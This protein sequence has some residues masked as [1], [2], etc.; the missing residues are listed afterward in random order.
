MDASSIPPPSSM[1]HERQTYQ[2]CLQHALNNLLQG[3]VFDRGGL[4][5]LADEL[6]KSTQGL[7]TSPTWFPPHR[8]ILGGNYD[9][10][11]LERALNQHQ[12]DLTWVAA[13]RGRRTV[14]P[15]IVISS[16]DLERARGIILNIPSPYAAW[17]W[18]F[19]GGRHWLTIIPHDLDLDEEG[20]NGE[21]QKERTWWN[22]DSY[23]SQPKCIGS[24]I[25]LQEH[26]EMA[27]TQGDAQVFLVIPEAE[28]IR[29]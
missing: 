26:L 5:A 24:R 8:S 28:A 1:Y 7:I 2:M 23:H 6:A 17:S 12:L 18:G 20:P 4:N 19:L 11:V 21:A 14:S 22:M 16:E 15:Q 3:P 27:V 25:K 10:N 29:K 13:K 9:V